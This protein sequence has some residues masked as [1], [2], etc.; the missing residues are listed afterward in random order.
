MNKKMMA[1]IS[2]RTTAG[3]LIATG[4]LVAAC[5]LG[6]T[7][8]DWAATDGAAG[9]INLDA[10]QSVFKNSES[11]TEFEK[12]VNEIY[13]G[14]GL[15]LI[16]ARQDPDALVIE[17]WE[18]L[19]SNYEIDDTEDDKLFEIVERNNQH[20]MR[21]YGANSY[22]HGGFGPGNFLFTYMM[23]STLS[24]RGYYYSTPPSYARGTLNSYRN[25]YRGSSRYRNQ[26]SRNGKYFTNNRKKFSSSG[27]STARSSFRSKQKS[28]GAFKSS[29]TG[30]RSSWGSSSGRSSVRSS[31]RGRS[32]SFRGYGGSQKIINYDRSS[33]E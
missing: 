27:L 9:R 13:E 16:R 29:T 11:A 28:S 17:G 21:G 5:S 3:A 6:P 4:P 24:P 7:Y 18:D 19:N 26:V 20:E 12:R 33:N 30:V 10:V 8:D 31:S 23:I 1:R 25:N 2:S 22:Y 15:V 32:G 14:D